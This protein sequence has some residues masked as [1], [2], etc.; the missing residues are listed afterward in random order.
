M[1]K[2]KKIDYFALFFSQTELPTVVA[3]GGATDR[4]TSRDSLYF[5]AGLHV[6]H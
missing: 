6:I 3:S 4:R 1:A 5:I 2:N